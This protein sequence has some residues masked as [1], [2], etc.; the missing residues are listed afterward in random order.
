[1]QPRIARVID[2]IGRSHPEGVTAPQFD[3]PKVT[4]TAVSKLQ[5][6]ADSFLALMRTLPKKHKFKKL[7][8]EITETADTLK[9]KMEETGQELSQLLETD[10]E[11]LPGI[12]ATA[13]G[14]FAEM[15]EREGTKLTDIIE[16][17]KTLNTLAGKVH[18]EEKTEPVEHE[19]PKKEV[20]PGE[21][22][23]KEE[24]GGELPNEPLPDTPGGTSAPPGVS[25]G[26]NSG[27][28]E[29]FST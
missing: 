4:E 26:S 19:M 15:L 29:L 24:S 23:K 22:D 21:K 1:M 28:N 14:D 5:D 18:K 13:L 11:E 27:L 7:V 20:K 17:T 10:E 16:L 3:S 8:G 9:R 12:K 6:H 25:P 2:A